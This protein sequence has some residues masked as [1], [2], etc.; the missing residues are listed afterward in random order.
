MT[1][2]KNAGVGLLETDHFN[3]TNPWGKPVVGWKETSQGFG[4]LFNP[5]GW[6]ALRAVLFKLAPESLKQWL[7][8]QILLVENPGAIVI[9][10]LDGRIALTR[11]FRMVGERLLPEAAGDYIRRL[12]EERL[13]NV[14]LD[15]LGRWMWETPRG[16]INDPKSQNLEEFILRTAKVE[17]LEESGYRL[18][19]VRIA[20]RVNAN[21]TFFAHAQYIVYGKIESQG[22]AKPEDLEM[23]GNSK[24]FTL[25]QLREMNQTGEFEDGLTLA[26]LALCGFA[27]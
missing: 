20:G 11:N 10:E 15:T 22:E 24:L 14:L 19:D 27:L 16:L 4:G 23:I 21:S 18:K 9:M 3:L 2:P 17:A 12:N 26:G 6:A 25:D 1:E 8:D 7:Y 5:Q 13:W